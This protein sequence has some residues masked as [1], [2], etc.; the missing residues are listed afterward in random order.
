MITALKSTSSGLVDRKAFAL[1][2]LPV[3]EIGCSVAYP[4]T[5]FVVRIVMEVV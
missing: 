2:L 4:V 3:R 1:M 5:P